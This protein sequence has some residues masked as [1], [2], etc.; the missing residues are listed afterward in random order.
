M[1]HGRI[2]EKK[3]SGY[4]I[5]ECA[6]HEKNREILKRKTDQIEKLIHGCSMQAG[7]SNRYWLALIAVSITVFTIYGNPEKTDKVTLPFNLGEVNAV[8]FY[9]ICT[10]ILSGITIA[11]VTTHLQVT[12][13]K[14]N[15]RKMCG[16]LAELEKKHPI[17][18]EE[19]DSPVAGEMITS[20]IAP[21]TNKV[22]TIPDHIFSEYRKDGS[23]RCPIPKAILY[24]VL[25]SVSA[26]FSYGIPGFALWL[27]AM[28]LPKE[29]NVWGALLCFV[30]LVAGLAMLVQVRSDFLWTYRAIAGWCGKYK[31][32]RKRHN[33]AN[34]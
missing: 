23:Y 11:Y 15:L 9:I 34:R 6:E 25:K 19:I 21:N 33:P 22:S 5:S 13:L 32:Y 1:D 10:V 4:R 20:C 7:V 14:D 3:A 26:L 30:A 17:P 16:Q 31:K 2:P 12:M 29:L 18:A 8:W 24:V 27:C 28:G